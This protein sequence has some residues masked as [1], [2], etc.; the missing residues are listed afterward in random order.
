MLCPDCKKELTVIEVKDKET[1][2]TR[3][4][5]CNCCGK[6]YMSTEKLLH[7]ERKRI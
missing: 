5:G 6:K 3:T 1:F 2:I 7:G 4:Y